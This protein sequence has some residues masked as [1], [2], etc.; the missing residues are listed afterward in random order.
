MSVNNC[1]F[2]GRMTRDPDLRATAG[3]LSVL[4]FSL[5]ING[6]KRDEVDFL[7]FVAFKQSAEFL[8]KYGKK[9]SQVYVEARAKTHKYTNKNGQEVNQVKF[10]VNNLQL[11]SSSKESTPSES[12]PDD[13][14]GF[15][16]L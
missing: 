9:G 14:G 3:G 7:N 16:G 6:I 13:L 2:I 1:I 8:A 5:A 15:D 12:T 10:A 11:I 4:D